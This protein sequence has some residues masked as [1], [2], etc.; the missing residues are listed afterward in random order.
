M[1]IQFNVATRNARLDA[2]ESTNGAS[3][4]LE[5]RSGAQPATCATAGSGTV[6]ATINL[7]ADWLAAASG[8]SK[9]IAGSWVDAAADAAGTAGHFRLYNSQATKDN[10][11]CFMQGSV[12][13]G[14]GGGDMTVDNTN[15]GVG[16]Q[17]T[18]TAFTLTDANA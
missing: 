10:T 3:C 7:P 4:S 6:L 12:T 15:F 16:Q 9:A 5:I 2:I 14:G 17:F 1:A 11:T 8:G 18:V 13:I